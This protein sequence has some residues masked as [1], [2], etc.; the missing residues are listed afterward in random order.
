MTSIP[1]PE[2]PPSTAPVNP[3]AGTL[4]DT[5]PATAAQ[6]EHD[7]TRL[8]VWHGREIRFSL[9][10]ELYYREL[11]AHTNAPALGDY[12]TQFDADAEAPRILYCAHHSAAELRALRL[13]PPITQV[14]RYDAWVEQNISL[15][16]FLAAARVARELM[17]AI[18]R[19]RSVP[20]A[21]G[22]EPDGAGN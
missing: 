22:D 16:E 12:I 14:E 15:A 10:A 2:D 1:I 7:F 3:A 19:A 5:A 6:R 11:R 8:F 21:T 4:I 20:A 9:A 18:T 13:L 17:E